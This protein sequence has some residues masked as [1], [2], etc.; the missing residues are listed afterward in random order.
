MNANKMYS[1]E[2][3]IRIVARSLYSALCCGQFELSKVELELEVVRKKLTA[4]N[5]RETN[6]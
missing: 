5:S 3:T 4:T 6:E 1:D 2:K